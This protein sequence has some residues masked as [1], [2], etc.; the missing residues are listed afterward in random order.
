[1]RGC[2][3]ARSKRRIPLQLKGRGFGSVGSQVVCPQRSKWK[4]QVLS[5]LQLLPFT[6]TFPEVRGVGETSL[7]CIVSEMPHIDWGLDNSGLGH[8]KK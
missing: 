4:P 8:G 3:E 1:M 6:C 2:T 5:V 7:P